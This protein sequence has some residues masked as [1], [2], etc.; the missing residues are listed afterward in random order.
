LAPL[1]CV[2]ALICILTQ[3]F[4]EYKVIILGGGGC[5]MGRVI[6][7][8]FSHFYAGVGKIS[9]GILSFENRF[10]D[11]DDFYRTYG[12]FKYPHSY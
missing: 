4:K 11:E 10:L 12:E 6:L 1:F 2:H 3:S 5:C 9:L 8:Y 7:V